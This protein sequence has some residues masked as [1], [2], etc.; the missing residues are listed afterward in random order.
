V[1]S[2]TIST[3]SVIFTVE[4]DNM[5]KRFLASGEEFIFWRCP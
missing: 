3:D 5:R 1:S 4:G 2:N